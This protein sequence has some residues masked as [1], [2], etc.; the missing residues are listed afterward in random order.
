MTC[1]QVLH[2][3]V[4]SGTHSVKVKAFLNSGS[5]STL[6]TKVLADKLKLTGEDQPLT[7]LNAVYMSTR[8]MSKLVNFQISSPSHLSKILISNTWVVENL[9]L[10]R[11]KINSNT[12]NK[13][14]N[15]LQDIQME[16][17]NSQE[18]MA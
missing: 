5:D 10:L 17:D 16:V 12:I 2:I 9:D 13:Q 18:I 8:T 3:Y 6:V 14:W 15:H 7:L 11:F 1:L 4:A